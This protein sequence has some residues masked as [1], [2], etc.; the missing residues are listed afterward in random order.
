GL[1]DGAQ[2]VLQNN[3]GDDLTVSAN[4][5]F[6]FATK[7][8]PANAYSVTVLTQPGS[9][10]Q[11]CTVTNG[12]GTLAGAH[13]TTVAI[14]CVSE[15]PITTSAVNGTLSCSPNPVLNGGDA[16]CTATP[17]AGYTFAGFSG[18]CSGL[19]CALTN[20]TSPKSVG[21][22][23]TLNTYS[24]TYSAGA[25]GSVTGSTSQTVGHGTDGT[26]VTAV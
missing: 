20:V 1:A 23:F 9:P 18:D 14:A 10:V 8:A 22:I 15:H 11:I 21:A 5:T 13:I 25:H 4:G 16:T 3:G 26:Q 2:V 17:S 6:R 7:L 19:T 12:S 24:L